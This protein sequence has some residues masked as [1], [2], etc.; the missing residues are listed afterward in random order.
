MPKLE[1]FQWDIAPDSEHI[2]TSITS[3][4]QLKPE[5]I[6]S[7]DTLRD[8][9]RGELLHLLA[10]ATNDP[11]IYRDSVIKIQEICL[12]MKDRGVAAILLQKTNHI[13]CEMEEPLAESDDVRAKPKVEQTPLPD[14]SPSIMPG[15]EVDYHPPGGCNHSHRH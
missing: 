13:T 12:T 3:T 11:S 6:S 15:L 8:I 2:K 5:N 9:C 4:S 1:S 14:T 7:L 10:I